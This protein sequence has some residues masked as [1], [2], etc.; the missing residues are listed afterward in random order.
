MAVIVNLVYFATIICRIQDS[1]MCEYD[2]LYRYNCIFKVAFTPQ[3]KC[4][5]FKNIIRLPLQGNVGVSWLE[6]QK[7]C[8]Q[9]IS[10]DRFATFKTRS[11]LDMLQYIYSR[12]S[13]YGF[14]FVGMKLTAFNPLPYYR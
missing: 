5:H 13:T 2:F 10:Q 6:N 14:A 4:I 1:P 9:K 11:E 3:G 8:N 12:R 7:S